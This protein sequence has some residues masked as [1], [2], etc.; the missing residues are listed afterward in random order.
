MNLGNLDT[1]RNV[2]HDEIASTLSAISNG[3]AG[4]L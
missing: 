1:S 2:F 4:V 3:S